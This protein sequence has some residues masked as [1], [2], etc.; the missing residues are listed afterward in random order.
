MNLVSLIDCTWWL[1]THCS[2]AKALHTLL[3]AKERKKQDVNIKIIIFFQRDGS[4]VG[5]E[6]RGCEERVDGDDLLQQGR[7]RPVRVPQHNY[8][9]EF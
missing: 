9:Y 3:E 8:F 6:L 4:T 2:R 5:G 7:D 1:A